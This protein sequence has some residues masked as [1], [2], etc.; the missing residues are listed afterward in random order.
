MAVASEGLEKLE[1][2]SLG[3][4]ARRIQFTP[5]PMPSDILGE[6]M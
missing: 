6:R 5:A 4:D 2:I 3:L 1:D